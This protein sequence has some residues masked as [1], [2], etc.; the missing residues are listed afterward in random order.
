MKWRGDLRAERLLLED[1]SGLG[2]TRI[3]WLL[4]APAVYLPCAVMGPQSSVV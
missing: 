3:K 2:R 1:T 4:R